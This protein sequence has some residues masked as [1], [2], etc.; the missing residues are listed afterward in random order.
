MWT[1]SWDEPRRRNIVS[2]GLR[3][4]M[5][6]GPK[7]STAARLKGFPGAAT[8]GRKSFLLESK[9]LCPALWG[10]RAAVSLRP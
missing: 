10:G 2:S 7:E 1:V 5:V 9:G 4:G 3:A 6:P 8:A